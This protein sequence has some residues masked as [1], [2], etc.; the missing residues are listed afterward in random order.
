M[1][2]RQHYG[3][4]NFCSP[5]PS[6]TDL[7]PRYRRLRSLMRTLNHLFEKN[8]AWAERI[9]RHKPDFFLELLPGPRDR[10]GLPDSIRF[11]KARIEERERGDTFSVGLIYDAV[12]KQLS[13]QLIEK[14]A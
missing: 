13:G 10:E 8:K 11:W 7:V 1:R 9:R 12:H 3:L 14:A 2:V 4:R 5:L 6:P